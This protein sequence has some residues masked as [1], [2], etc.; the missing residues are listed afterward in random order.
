MINQIIATFLPS[1]LGLK[2]YNK[3]SK[4]EEKLQKHVERYLLYVL[5]IN[6]IVY[7]ITIYL[8]KCPEIIFTYTFTVKYIL[9]AIIIAIIFPIIEKIIND[10][11]D[12]G[13]EVKKNEEKN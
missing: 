7:A 2:M 1:I 3:L 4:T 11:I 5:F 9:L 6:L 10:N 8:F 13:V 12:I